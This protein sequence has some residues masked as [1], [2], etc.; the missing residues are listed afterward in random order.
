M[1]HFQKSEFY[2]IVKHVFGNSMDFVLPS[3][4]RNCAFPRAGGNV[5]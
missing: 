1:S 4:A 2:A 3:R 5:E